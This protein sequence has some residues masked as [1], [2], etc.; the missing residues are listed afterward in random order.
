MEIILALVALGLMFWAYK[1]FKKPVDTPQDLT[2]PVPYKVET[3]AAPVVEHPPVAEPVQPTAPVVDT[4]PVVETVV[5][6]VPVKKTRK[7]RATKVAKATEKKPVNVSSMKIAKAK[8][9]K[10]KKA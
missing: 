6:E 9:A 2:L 3:P 8:K 5:A 1:A 7:P 10:S 4:T